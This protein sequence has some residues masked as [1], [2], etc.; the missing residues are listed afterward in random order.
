MQ[1]INTEYGVLPS[2][3]NVKKLSMG[4]PSKGSGI[5]SKD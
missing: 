1:H 3:E 5:S 2:T 4:D